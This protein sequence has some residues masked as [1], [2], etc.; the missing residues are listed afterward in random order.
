M[1][2][3]EVDTEMVIH[4]QIT[5]LEK[6]M[7]IKTSKL[8]IKLNLKVKY[9]WKQKQTQLETHKKIHRKAQNL[10]FLRHLLGK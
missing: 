9:L 4:T 2:S 3:C 8:S 10:L 5:N 1:K 6:E 7:M